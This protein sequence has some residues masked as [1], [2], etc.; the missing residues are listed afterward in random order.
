MP[1]ATFKDYVLDQLRDFGGVGARA[2]FGGFGVYK[3][4][5]MFGLIAMDELYFK[6]DDSNRPD[7]EARKCQPFVYESKTK[8][9]SMSYWRVPDDVLENP[10]DLKEWAMKAYDVALKK[11]S[12]S[13]AKPR[14]RFRSAPRRKRR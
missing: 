13:V 4:G 9:I 7:Y 10:D 6:V 5:V 1:D 2:M 12:A 8:S 3:A 14:R 11:R